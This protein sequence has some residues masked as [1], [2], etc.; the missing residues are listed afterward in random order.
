M[1]ALDQLG[2]REAHQAMKAEILDREARHHAARERRSSQKLVPLLGVFLRGFSIRAGLREIAD[3]SSREA[4]ARSRRIL[5]LLNRE[6]GREEGS[7]RREEHRSVF[8]ALNDQHGW[9]Q[10]A[11]ELRGA[12]NVALTG[13]QIRFSLVDRENIYAAKGFLQLLGFSGDPEVHAVASH[14]T[15]FLDLIQYALLKNGID[16]GQENIRSVAMSR[17]QLWIEVLKNIERGGESLRFV[18]VRIIRA[19]PVKGFALR[20]LDAVHIDLASGEPIQV[21]FREVFSHDADDVDGSVKGRGHGEV[22]DGPSKHGLGFAGGSI[23]RVKGQRTH[24]ED[25]RRMRFHI[26]WLKEVSRIGPSCQ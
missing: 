17:A 18:Q 9:T 19:H 1:L 2:S 26:G 25:G 3:E 6:G 22:V 7:A 20:D 11:D 21:R 5:H 23:N 24:S 13:E 15:R 16:I 12:E 10:L 4:I 8:T 14:E